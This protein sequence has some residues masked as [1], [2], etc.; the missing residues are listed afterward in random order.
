M[1]R[2]DPTDY[3]ALIMQGMESPFAWLTVGNDR[4]PTVWTLQAGREFTRRYLITGITPQSLYRYK[5]SCINDDDRVEDYSDM[6]TPP[7]EYRSNLPTAD[8][9]PEPQNLQVT[10]T[11]SAM[12]KT[13]FASWS[14]VQGA[15][16]YEI[17]YGA[18][19]INWTR[20]GQVN[21]SSVTL[22]L[23]IGAVWLRVAAV[24]GLEQ[25][26]WAVWH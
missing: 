19:G 11:S 15:T 22:Q 3:A 14:E 20:Y 9:L 25:S 17:Q 18:D 1:A 16:S 24:R 8:T 2:L 23:G 6:P 10:V 26:G 13:V 5:I 21:V 7:W 12:G 4:M